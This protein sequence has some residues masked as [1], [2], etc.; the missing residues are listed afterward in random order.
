M[1]D[2]TDGYGERNA[3]YVIGL[4]IAI[5]AMVATALLVWFVIGGLH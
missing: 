4:C 3:I 5:I 2:S 1:L